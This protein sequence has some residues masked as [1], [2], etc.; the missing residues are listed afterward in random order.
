MERLIQLSFLSFHLNDI[1]FLYF[2][3]FMFLICIINTELL[4]I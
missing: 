1:N 3:F 4:F 2:D